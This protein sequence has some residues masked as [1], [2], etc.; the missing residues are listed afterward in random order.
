MSRLIN[1]LLVSFL[2]VLANFAFAQCPAGP[3]T[4]DTNTDLAFGDDSAAETCLVAGSVDIPSN[5]SPGI[6]LTNS[7]KFVIGEGNAQT[8][9]RTTVGNFVVAGNSVFTMNTTD[10]LIVWGDLTMNGNGDLTITAGTLY[11]YGSL[12]ISDNAAFGAGGT[13]IILGDLTIS[14]ANAAVVVAGGFSVG[15]TAD[16][17]SQ[18]IT[19][20]D[21]A[22]FKA[23]SLTS[24]GTL[25]VDGGGT[26]FVTDGLDDVTTVNT[27]NATGDV[28]CTDNCCGTLCDPAS[29]ELT[30]EGNAVLP[31]TLYSFEI[32]RESNSLNITWESISEDNFSHYEIYKLSGEQTNKIADVPSTGNSYGDVYHFID[33]SPLLGKNIYQLRSIDFDGYAEWFPAK[34]VIFQPVDVDFKV[35]PNPGLPSELRTDIYESFQ[36]EVFDLSG[37]RIM[38]STVQDKDLSVTQLLKPGNYIF[39]YTVNGHV[40]NQTMIIR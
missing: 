19:I 28:V 40:V 20:T 37:N 9:A 32:T 31:I 11:V 38:L 4:Y 36:L 23:D 5:K 3:G 8:G 6:L 29:D 21:G 22:V 33:R 14:G 25:T 27:A 13:I 16:L 18:D 34:A 17:G 39:R 26:I 7:G 1:I 12:T 30:P 35:F 10:S 15:G 24:T 2:M